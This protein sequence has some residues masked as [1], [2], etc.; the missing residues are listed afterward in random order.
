MSLI[1]IL[2]LRPHCALRRQLQGFLSKLSGVANSFPFCITSFFRFLVCLILV[3]LKIELSVLV[4]PNTF[5]GQLHVGSDTNNLG[6]KNTKLVLFV[7][8]LGYVNS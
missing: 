1:E 8:V 5:Y 2:R 6:L 4:S 3:Q 7:E